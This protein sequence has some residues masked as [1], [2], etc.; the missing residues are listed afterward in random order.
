MVRG[1][2]FQ[3][4]SHTLLCSF[5]LASATFLDASCPVAI[6]VGGP[7][8]ISPTPGPEN[9]DPILTHLK[10]VMNNHYQLP[11]FIP[12]SPD[13]L[14]Q[15]ILQTNTYSS[16]GSVVFNP[17]NDQI[18]C[19]QIGQNIEYD[20]GVTANGNTFSIATIGTNVFA[21]SKDGGETWDYLPP[22]QQ[23]IPL[24]G[25][26]SQII[27]A[28]LGPGL[29]LQY[30]KEGKLFASGNGF[31]DMTINPPRTAPLTGFLFAESDN[32]GE[33]WERTEIVRTSD[34]NWW[35]IGGPFAATGRGP[36][37]FYTTIDPAHSNIIHCTTNEVINPGILFGDIFAFRSTNAGKTFSKPKKAYNMVDDPVWHKEH[38]DPNISDPLYL[39]YGG[40]VLLAAHT[41][42][43]NENI[44]IIPIQR[45]YPKKHSPVYTRDPSDTNFDQA[46]VRSFDKGKTWSKV[47][48]ATDQYITPAGTHDPALPIFD[49]LFLGPTFQLSTPVVSPFTG[50]IYLTYD[51]GNTQLYKDP[52]K[53]QFSPY[54]LASASSDQG[55]TWSRA[56]KINR[57]PTNIKKGAQQA[58]G[59]AAVMT[60]DGHYVV[61]YYD[62]RKW[63]GHL[64][65]DIFT[66]SLSTD[67]WIDIYK[68]LDDP[69]GG[70]TGIGLDFVKEFRVTPQSFNARVMAAYANTP[71][72]P[73]LPTGVGGIYPNT[74]LEGLGMSVNDRNELFV[75]F[76]MNNE[77]DKSKIHTGFKGLT[78]DTNNRGNIFM[79]RYQFPKPSNE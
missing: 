31:F 54:V 47:A 36:R 78:I 6:P 51:A 42:V 60:K 37:E 27:N 10:K 16:F 70:S 12:G 66:T 38:F 57:T 49:S 5:I 76:S 24:G 2:T 34:V 20:Y 74:T 62:Y 22:V 15:I 25:K 29:F 50:R 4:W 1:N 75:V 9:P 21:L 35:I 58:Y 72:I 8:R 26:I 46:V 71:P 61:A 19:I 23:I 73:P 48:G 32:N 63:K 43:Y 52:E 13:F 69:H 14:S 40:L 65:E 18:M 55:E 64:G 59:H 79:R 44:V 28:S 39:K 3:K 11:V 68:E 53:A 77:S 56:V 33:S 17:L 7:Q 41:V 67:V 45:S 30:S